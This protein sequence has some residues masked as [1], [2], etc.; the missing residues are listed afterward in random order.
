M[1][2]VGIYF[3][4]LFIVFAFKPNEVGFEI[5]KNTIGLPNELAVSI[6]RNF[7]STSPYMVYSLLLAIV[8]YA[9]LG[10]LIYTLYIIIWYTK[11]KIK[12]RDK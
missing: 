3:F 12:K 6:V 8:F 11:T 2:G 7:G 1:V 9:M 10:A 5:I 4:S